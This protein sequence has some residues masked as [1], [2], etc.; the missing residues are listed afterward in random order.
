MEEEE[1]EGGGYYFYGLIWFP[2]YI[3]KNLEEKKG[4]PAARVRSILA[5]RFSG[6]KLIFFFGLRLKCNFI[7]QDVD[8][9]ETQAK[10]NPPPPKSDG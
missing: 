7:L 8:M 10:L 4:I 3:V 6:N 5:M 9:R 2:N 1:G